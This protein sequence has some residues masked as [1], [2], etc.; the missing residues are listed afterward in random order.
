M[1]QKGKCP[2]QLSRFRT[3]N[4]MD[5]RLPS[6]RHIFFPKRGG[7]GWRVSILLPL[8][9]YHVILTTSTDAFLETQHNVK[10]FASMPSTSSSTILRVPH[11]LQVNEQF[12][13]LP[14]A[15]SATTFSPRRPVCCSRNCWKNHSNSYRSS[16]TRHLSSRWQ[17][18]GDDIR[19]SSKLRRN[20]RRALDFSKHPVRNTLVVLNL[21]AFVYQSISSV[22][23]ICTQYPTAWP[24]QAIPIVW[25]TITGSSRPGPMTMDFVHSKFLS[26]RQPHRFLTAGFLHGNIFHL[27]I[28]MDALRRMPSWLEAG[29]GA[30]VY[31]TTYLAAIVAGNVA[32]SATALN[33]T[34][35]LG[36]S[37]GICGLYGLLYVCLVRMGNAAAAFRVLKGMAILFLVG[38]IMT[39]V[40]NAGHAGGLAAGIVLGL[41]TGPNYRKSY[42]LRRKNSIE[43]DEY[44]RDYRTA[45]GFDKVPSTRGLLPV[46]LV[47]F[48]IFVALTTQA[49]FRSMPRL[50][51][52]G[53]LHP[54]SLTGLL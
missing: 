35:C 33:G 25:D 1:L 26:F 4:W 39:N 24:S 31:L 19:W 32:H 42:A 34:L 9:L 23:S 13:A 28:N 15:N 18:E 8:F 36:A 53:L 46:S 6:D 17:W 16:L 14:V 43:F 12:T 38:A 41:L 47:W 49:K 54:G 5:R 48:A 51:L 21:L 44:S 11:C 29:L 7:G 3:A 37:G 30:P 27:L 2:A 22:R 10:R 45:M 20:A 52:Q 40:S 50:L